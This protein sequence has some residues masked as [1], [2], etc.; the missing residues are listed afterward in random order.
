MPIR[1]REGRETVALAPKLIQTPQRAAR[2]TLEPGTSDNKTRAADRWALL[3]AALVPIVVYWNT[4]YHGFVFDDLPGIVDNPLVRGATRCQDLWQI[5]AQRWRPLIQL[6]YAATHVVF[7]FAPAAYHATNVA[8][9]T[10]NVLLVY[11]IASQVARLWLPPDRRRLFAAAAGLLFAV[12][13]LHSEAVAYVWGRSSSLCAFFCFSSILLLMLG[14][15]QKS[16]IERRVL[17]GCALVAGLLAWKSKEE[18]ITLPLV[19]SGFLWLAGRK[20]AAAATALVPVALVAA[21]WPDFSSLAE[22][23]AQNQELVLAGASPSLPRWT[24]FLTEVQSAVFYYLGKFLIPVNLN[25]DPYVE[26]VKRLGDLRFIAS[27]LV[28]GC[29]AAAAILVRRRQPA[30]SFSLIA[31]L[32]SPLTAYACMPLADVVAEHRVYIT[33]LGFALLAACAVALKPKTG[34]VVLAAA[35][36]VLSLATFERNKVWAGSETLWRDAERKSPQLARPH[37]NLG[38]AYQVANRYE[39]ALAEYAHALSVNPRLAL[40]YSNMSSI[41][42]H[43]GDLVGAESLLKKAIELSPGRIGPYV[44]LAAIELQRGAPAEAIQVLDQTGKLGDFAVVHFS[45]GEALF[46]LGKYDQARSEYSRAVELDSSAEL[47]HRAALRLR[48]IDSKTE[49]RPVAP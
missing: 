47:Q 12:H 37:L 11:A 8:L 36:V 13:P 14:H 42:V 40:A 22:K 7:G 44:K 2:K 35:V 20:A 33:G 4:L 43:R 1:F 32:V 19:L 23:V 6:S 17:F 27:C 39:E 49:E 18:A 24:F 26:P 41:S 34:A 21:R 45:R 25:V 46:A 48:E 9:H 38:V 31:L 28:L 29:C 30:V 16:A 3:F 5:L 15:Q 10:A